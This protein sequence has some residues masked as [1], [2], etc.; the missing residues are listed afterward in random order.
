MINAL[1]KLIGGEERKQYF[2]VIREL[3]AREIKRKYARS[4]LGIIWSVLNPLLTMIVMTM[5]FSYMF[6]RSIVNYPLY[7]LTG[8]TFWSLFSTSTNTAMS[9]LVDNRTLLMKVKLPKQTF[10]LSRIYTALVN[11]GYSLVA[12]AFIV[13]IYCLSGKLVLNAS[14]F[15]LPVDVF[16]TLLFAIGVSYILSIAYV[17]FGDVKYLYSVLLTLW[18]YTSAIFY[19]VEQLPEMIKTVIGYNPVYVSIVFAREIIMNGKVPAITWWVRLIAYGI[20]SFVV[21]YF[22]FKKH[23]NKVMQKI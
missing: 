14:I 21:G 2:F 20:C 22:V 9:A 7:Y 6:R 10:V 8:S 12:F 4:F 18:M 17:F 11:F 19:P 15:L 3:T 5:I 23:E 16:F 1:H 13:L